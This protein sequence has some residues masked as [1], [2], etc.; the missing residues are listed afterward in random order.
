M[1]IYVV[2]PGDTA[3]SIAKEQNAP[4]SAIADLNQLEYPYRLAEGPG[5]A[6]SR[7]QQRP[8]E[9]AALDRRLRLSVYLALGAA[10]DAAL[11]DGTAGISYGFTEEGDLIAP[12]L[13]DT[14][15]LEEAAAAGV[16]TALTLTPLGEGG[17]FNNRLVTVLVGSR[18]ARRN[19]ARNLL[20]VL[21]EKGYQGVNVDF[22]YVRAKTGMLLRILWRRRPA[23]CIP[24]GTT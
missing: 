2:R 21:E 5:A 17:Y 11:S 1:E 7:R 14:W 18:Q 20:A 9:T 15:M 22:E 16:R 8:A 23:G 3:E 6:D 4:L 24:G 10:A 13:D 19:L 12:S